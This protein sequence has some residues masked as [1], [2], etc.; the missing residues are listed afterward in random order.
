M[1][2]ENRYPEASAKE[3][4]S[5]TGRGRGMVPDKQPEHGGPTGRA[6]ESGRIRAGMTEIQKRTLIGCACAVSCETLFG[7]SYLFTKKI[8][9]D[10]DAVTLL[11]W[12][13][14]LAFI[15]MNILL[16]TGYINVNI[17][18][19]HLPS[20][21]K[22]AFLQPIAYF[23]CETFGIQM[24][25]ASESGAII[26]SIPIASLAASILFL[27]KK[28]TRLQTFGICLTVLGVVVCVIAKGFE[29]S[30][31][32]IGYIMLCMAVLSYSL[33]CVSAEKAYAITNIEKTYAM[34]ACGACFFTTM[35]IGRSIA[36]GTAVDWFMLPFQNTEFLFSV[37][38]L[39]IASS[40]L[41]FLLFNM[42]IS[43][44]GTNKAS[45]FV[46]ISTAVSYWP[47]FLCSMK[48]FH[49]K[50][51]FQKILLNLNSYIYMVKL[52]PK[53][54]PENCWLYVSVDG[55]LGCISEKT[56]N[57]LTRK[58]QVI[59]LSIPEGSKMRS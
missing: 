55:F 56:T 13:F 30:F 21:L 19:K 28:P 58:T 32:G 7:L 52:T 59:C 12:R 23:T 29:S 54:N 42:S 39:G 6:Q 35:A 14:L 53:I 10:V 36:A 45:S 1:D 43:Y 5:R 17:K 22:I 25:T 18:K 8:T 27:H 20:L 50:Y 9:S 15:M 44:I 38:Y 40:V 26:A 11:G 16:A 57:N 51:D 31:N 33:Y 2:G 24:T 49:E 47:A 4:A 46:G 3:A 48:I 41:S 34:I 37:I